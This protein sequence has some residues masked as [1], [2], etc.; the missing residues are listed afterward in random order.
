MVSV[1]PLG[2][3]NRDCFGQNGA[4]TRGSSASLHGSNSRWRARARLED[5]RLAAML[6]AA[7]D[8]GLSCNAIPRCSSSSSRHREDVDTEEVATVTTW[9]HDTIS[10][11]AAMSALEATTVF[12]HESGAAHCKRLSETFVL[13][14]EEVLRRAVGAPSDCIDDLAEAVARRFAN[15][16]LSTY[17]HSAEALWPGRGDSLRARMHLAP[18]GLVEYSLCPSPGIEDIPW[19]LSGEGWW[20]V[21]PPD[22]PCTEVALE[23]CQGLKAGGGADQCEA[24]PPRVLRID[25]RSCVRVVEGEEGDEEE[26]SEEDG[27]EEEEE[28]THHG[29]DGAGA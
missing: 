28:E 6:S 24:E 4:G 10:W 16:P 5:E 1:E 27:E 13:A 29:Q 22:G 19:E 8:G 2:V 23:L 7:A 9:L 20:R 17:E 25:L 18:S 15:T 14:L 11:R 3:F 26:I 21:L 12:E